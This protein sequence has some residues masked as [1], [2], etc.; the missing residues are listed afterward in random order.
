MFW[1][2]FASPLTKPCRKETTREIHEAL[3][4]NLSGD[5]ILLSVA[6]A[7]NACRGRS[8]TYERPVQCLE[9]LELNTELR[10]KVLGGA[11]AR[12]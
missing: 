1:P 8:R 4:E 9:Q 5:Y 3:P 11:A 7:R 12:S 2:A 6:R 10:A